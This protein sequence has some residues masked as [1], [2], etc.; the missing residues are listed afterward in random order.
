MCSLDISAGGTLVQL[1][2]ILQGLAG[3]EALSL[4]AVGGFLLGHGAEDRFPDIAEKGGEI[5][6]DS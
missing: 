1:G 5:E 6:V 2:D 4:L 3:Q